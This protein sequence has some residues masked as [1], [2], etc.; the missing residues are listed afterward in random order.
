MSTNMALPKLLKVRPAVK[1]RSISS[2][3]NFSVALCVSG[4]LYSWGDGSNGQLGLGEAVVQ[5]QEPTKISIASERPRDLVRFNRV[6]CGAM[7]A[8]AVSE[9]GGFIYVWGSNQT[10]QA[11]VRW[12]LL[13]SE[14]LKFVDTKLTP[15]ST[16]VVA[17][18]KG[19]RVLFSWGD[20][21]HVIPIEDVADDLTEDETI[22]L[23]KSSNVGPIKLLQCDDMALELGCAWSTTMNILW[24][25]FTSGQK[26]LERASSDGQ[27]NA[28]DYVKV[29]EIQLEAIVD[30]QSERKVAVT[31]PRDSI[32]SS[33]LPTTPRVPAVTKGGS[34]MA[35]K[36]T[37][38]L[39]LR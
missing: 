10:G 38:I 29:N 27:S 30:K 25:T 15:T 3:V 5:V 1:F 28:Q 23:T 21:G 4:K 34:M 18:Q 12:I 35:P 8:L 16:V 32:V 31:F 14:K 7:H 11:T 22:R 9:C 33:K 26:V 24:T 36:D 2:G 37:Y 39:M 20:V 17:N 6:V 19:T 13:E